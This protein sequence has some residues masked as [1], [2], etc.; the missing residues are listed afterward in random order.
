MFGRSAAMSGRAHALKNAIDL[1]TMRF[2][3]FIEGRARKGTDSGGNV[4]CFRWSC[5]EGW[6]EDCKSEIADC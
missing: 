2:I 4:R 1:T 3:G 5:A 6:A